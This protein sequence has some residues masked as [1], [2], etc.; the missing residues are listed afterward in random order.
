MPR[1]GTE[2]YANNGWL[3]ELPKPS[4]K[5]T[6][7]NVVLIGPKDAQKLDVA[8]GDLF[9]ITV[10][11]KK[12]KAPAWI[13]PGM[14]EG[15]FTISFGYGRTASGRV[16]TGIGYNAY[17]IQDAASPYVAGG[18]VKNTKENY[19]LADTQE[20]QTMAGRA[21]VRVGRPRRI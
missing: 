9:E 12:V 14:P 5:L 17:L 10:N 11:G 7:D 3:Q 8:A 19:R 6:W 1:S 15:S 13:Q 2:T 21:P 18:D 20:T 16:G 4:T